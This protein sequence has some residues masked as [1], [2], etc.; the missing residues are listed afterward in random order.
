MRSSSSADRRQDLL[1]A[2]PVAMTVSAEAAWI[3]VVYAAVDVAIGTGALQ[4]GFWAFVVGASA[5]RFVAR[6]SSGTMLLV[7]SVAA[8]ACGWLLDPA[9]WTALAGPSPISA[10]ATNP[11]GCY[12]GPRCGVG[13]A[14]SG[15]T[16]PTAHHC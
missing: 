13:V 3:T 4:L 1:A 8:G 15:P 9:V 10:L 11:G 7:A 2:L 14:V 12:S 5:G 6:R 16:L